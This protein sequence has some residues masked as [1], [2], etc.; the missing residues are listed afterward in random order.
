MRQCIIILS[1]AV[2]AGLSGCSPKLTKYTKDQ[3]REN[4]S[5]QVLAAVD[6]NCMMCHKKDFATPEEICARKTVII[7]SVVNGRMPKFGSLS[8]EDLLILSKW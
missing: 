2:I 3:C 1:I 5:P 4:P 6:D 7:D 8:K